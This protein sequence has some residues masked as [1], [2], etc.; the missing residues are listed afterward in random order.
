M[1]FQQKKWVSRHWTMYLIGKVDL[2]SLILVFR[3]NFIILLKNDITEVQFSAKF[4]FYVDF[5]LGFCSEN[6]IKL[7]NSWLW[8]VQIPQQPDLYSCFRSTHLKLCFRF[9]FCLTDLSSSEAPVCRW[10]PAGLVPGPA[11]HVR[12]SALPAAPP[13]SGRAHPAVR[14]KSLQNRASGGNL[15]REVQRQETRGEQDAVW[16][17]DSG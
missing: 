7:L 4:L 11:R 13:Q 15:H 6:A 5:Y 1:F 3:P 2:K 17:V 16:A 12:V 14:R 10:A 8:L 9:D